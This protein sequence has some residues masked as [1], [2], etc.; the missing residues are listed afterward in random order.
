MNLKGYRRVASSSP[1]TIWPKA[2]VIVLFTSMSQKVSTQSRSPRYYSFRGSQSP[3]ITHS[4][5]GSFLY[6]GLTY[7]SEQ[8]CHMLPLENRCSKKQRQLLQGSCSIQLIIRKGAI[9]ET[10]WKF[11]YGHDCNG[12]QETIMYTKRYF[13]ETRKKTCSYLF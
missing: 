12:I 9:I 4:L 8:V 10:N 6:L 1:I 13:Y 5:K 3:N 7:K 2:C 11:P